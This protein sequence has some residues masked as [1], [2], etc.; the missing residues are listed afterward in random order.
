[1]KVKELMNEVVAVEKDMTLKE[2]AKVMSD[3][4]IGSLVVISGKKILGIVTERD[5]VTNASNLGKG[6]KTAMTKSVF[7][8][9]PDEEI[10]NAAIIMKKH[11]IHKV[12]VVEN[13]ELVGIITATDLIAHSD[14]LDEEFFFE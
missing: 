6:I 2:A 13:D 11:K 7:T 5:I 4:N 12:P 3:K 10:D 14:D 8:I 9:S 1:M